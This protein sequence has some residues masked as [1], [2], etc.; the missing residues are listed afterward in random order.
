MQHIVVIFGDVRDGCDVPCR[1]H[2]EQP[3]LDIVARMGKGPTWLDA[4]LK[5]FAELGRG[6]LVLVRNPAADELRAEADAGEAEA[7]GEGHGSARRR[8]ER[9]REIG[10]GAQILR[11]LGVRSI[12]LLA[13]REQHYVG[14]GGYGIEIHRTIRVDG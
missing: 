10:V 12:A 5:K 7:A 11:H 2:R 9:W 14:L 1:I 13:T 6:I 4:A 3:V 8:V